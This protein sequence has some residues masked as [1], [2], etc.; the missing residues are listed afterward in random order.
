M[1]FSEDF[2]KIESGYCVIRDKNG[3]VT[4]IHK[5]GE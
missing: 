2:E 3:K 1:E 4:D 5:F